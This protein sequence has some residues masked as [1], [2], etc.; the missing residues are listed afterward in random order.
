M[1]HKQVGEHKHREG[2]HKRGP[3][4]H[5]QQQ[6]AAHM[7]SNSSINGSANK[8]RV[9]M[10]AGWA[11]MNGEHKWGQGQMR[12]GT[13]CTRAGGAQVQGFIISI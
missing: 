13:A 11:H 7:A 10:S 1:C 8:R 6:M 2:T 9:G 4:Q 3:E 12:A 5:K